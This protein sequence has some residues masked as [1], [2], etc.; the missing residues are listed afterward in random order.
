MR[1]LYISEMITIDGFFEGP[2]KE[3]DRHN[4]DA[5]FNEYAIDQLDRTGLL[6]FGRVAY[7]LMASYWPTELAKTDD[8]MVARMMNEIPK[9]VVSNSLAEA[10][11]SNTRVIREN[12]GDEI[13]KLKQEPGKDIGIF[14]SSRLA[15]TLLE[16]GL[17]DEVRMFIAP[18]VLGMGNPLFPARS[19][20]ID[21]KLLRT[22][23][24]RSGNVLL[25]YQPVNKPHSST[26]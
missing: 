14:G 1:K 2:N 23:K 18:V 9:I 24:F 20:R 13:L 22:E 7:E 3:I 21:F 5:E 16:I 4:V 6:V 26:P 12:I 11:W 19:G 8:P 17:I 15:A 10:S 25:C